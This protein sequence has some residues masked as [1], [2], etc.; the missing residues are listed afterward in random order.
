MTNRLLSDPDAL[1]LILQRLRVENDLTESLL[2]L[3][4]F[5]AVNQYTREHL[6]ANEEELARDLLGVDMGMSPSALATMIRQ[7]SPTHRDRLVHLAEQ[8]NTPH[9]IECF[10]FY[11]CAALAIKTLSPSVTAIGDYAFLQ[12]QAL[13]INTLSPSVTAIGGGAF[14]NCHSLN[15]VEW[16]APVLTTLGTMRFLSVRI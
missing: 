3:R 8:W 4:N 16:H 11:E 7:M 1:T 5:S 2:E 9:A 15:V 10:Y 14:D 13:A 12:C 6:H